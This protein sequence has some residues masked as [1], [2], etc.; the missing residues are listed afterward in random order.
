MLNIRGK[1]RLR[2]KVED[3]EAWTHCHLLNHVLGSFG[4]RR[5]HC[6]SLLQCSG[7]WRY[8][9][10]QDNITAHTCSA[11]GPLGRGTGTKHTSLQTKTHMPEG[12][13]K[14]MKAGKAVGGGGAL[15]KALSNT[16]TGSFHRE[17]SQPR[18]TL[19]VERFR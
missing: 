7:C 10:G 12:A 5:I 3:P 18:G 13:R 2:T 14:E 6:A 1:R 9:C 8:S 4:S 19:G 16:M 15:K 11:W 17:E